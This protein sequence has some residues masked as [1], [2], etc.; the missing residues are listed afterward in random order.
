[1]S[2]A[3]AVDYPRPAPVDWDA[4]AKALE[5]IQ[6][7]REPALVKQ[8]SRD[9][10]WYSP[11]LKEQL[12]SKF[13]DILVMPRNI[14]EVVRIAATC[15]KFRAPLV[16]R[17]GGT[18]NYGQAMPLEGGVILETTLMDKILWRKHDMLRVEMGKKL[19][20]IDRE[21]RPQGWE[22]RLHPSTK[23]TATIGG[24]I[25][26]GSGGIGSVTWGVL[27][28]RGQIQALKVVTVEEKPRIIELRGDAVQRANH[29]YGTNGIIVELEMPL[30]P[31]EPWVD[32][33]VAFDD[34]KASWKFAQEVAETSPIV[35]KLV[36]TCAWPIPEYFRQL[37]EACPDGKHIAIAMISET[38][39]EAFGRIVEIYGG[40]ITYEKKLDEADKAVPLYEYTWNH[41]TLQALKV[42]RT[43]TYLQ[44]LFPV[45]TN[46]DLMMHMHE[47]YGDEVMIHAEFVRIMGKVTNSALQIVRY[48][49]P[50]RLREI[51]EYHE[52]MNCRIANPHTYVL[53]DGG[54]KKIDADQLSFKFEADPHGL[55]NPGK[56][57]GW[58]QAHAMGIKSAADVGRVNWQTIGSERY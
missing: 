9:F 13:G 40:K 53:E 32:V 2:Q 54:M 51:I 17:G 30:G 11:I 33:I 26:G 42:D 23:R 50:E 7:V 4:F 29:A 45:G 10:Y 18:G 41:T 46:I 14:D 16:V 21:M 34:L 28:E 3:A 58:A 35:K 20:D 48:T 31:A 1:M 43:V 56:M 24:F 49:T 25:A 57:R 55:L 27:R 36:S 47:K 19:I 5:G 39:M 38:S 15:A 8:K 37:R 12:K 52:K 44:T 22:I 6:I